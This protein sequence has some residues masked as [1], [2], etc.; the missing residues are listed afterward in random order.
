LDRGERE[1]ASVGVCRDVCYYIVERYP[2][3]GHLPPGEVDFSQ[4]DPWQVDV[5][6]PWRIDR[7]ARVA[8]RWW[9]QPSKTR[10]TEF[11]TMAFPV[12]RT[13]SKS[14]DDEI[15]LFENGVDTRAFFKIDI[16]DRQSW[17]KVEREKIDSEQ[18]RLERKLRRL[19]IKKIDFSSL[20]ALEEV[21]FETLTANEKSILETTREMVGLAWRRAQ[22][23]SFGEE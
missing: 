11:G 8:L 9:S 12:Q 6:C 4:I 10:G 17:A 18:E 22:L 1:S 7:K 3:L 16:G 14:D 2:D 23:N 21:P 20:V 15:V 13:L 5:P 19:G